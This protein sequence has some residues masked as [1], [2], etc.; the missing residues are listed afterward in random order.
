MVKIVI[1]PSPGSWT[2]D[3]L[4]D[5]VARSLAVDY[6]GPTN[7]R[8]RGVPDRRAIRWYTTLG[9]I[10]RP[11]ALRGRT[12]LY[13]RRHLLQLVAIKRL[14][15]EGLTL[16]DVQAR[17]GGASDDVLARLARMPATEEVG[18]AIGGGFW[19]ARPSAAAAKSTV[20]HPLEAVQAHAS[21]DGETLNGLILTPGVRLIFDHGPPLTLIE[22][23]TFRSLA[24]PL[25]AALRARDHPRKDTR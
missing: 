15:A 5:E 17:L 4:A 13:G 7:G 8:V 10:D 21:L 1:S 22:S 18:A 11:S 12:A 16:E 3:D 14:Q 24:A 6:G 23:E 25:L 2:L 20:I 19:K 9:L